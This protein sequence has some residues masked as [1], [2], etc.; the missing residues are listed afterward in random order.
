MLIRPWYRRL[1][2]LCSLRWHLLR[3]FI[4]VRP[5]SRHQAS[6]RNLR[7]HTQ[8]L[9]R[10]DRVLVPRPQGDGHRWQRPCARRQEG[11]DYAVAERRGL[12]E[13]HKWEGQCPADVHGREAEDQG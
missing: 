10:R 8:E 7:I 12:C 3:P 13:T 6:R 5:Q 11:N 2:L 4:R 1:P 9:R